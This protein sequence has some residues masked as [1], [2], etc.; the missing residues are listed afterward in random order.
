MGLI[1]GGRNLSHYKYLRIQ[2]HLGTESYL[3]YYFF[4]AVVSNYHQLSSSERHPIVISQFRQNSS[5]AG[6]HS[7]LMGLQGQSHVQAGLFLTWRLWGESVSRLIQVFSRSQFLGAGGLGFQMEVV[8]T[9]G[10]HLGI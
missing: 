2:D 6:V 5:G 4:I 9:P 3:V 8:F 7:Q 10:G 1:P